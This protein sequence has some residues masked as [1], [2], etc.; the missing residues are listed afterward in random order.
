MDETADFLV[1]GL[2]AM[3]SAALDQLAQSGASVIGLDR[4]APPHTMGSSHGE[5][6]ITRQ[7]V[8]E[9]AAYV[10]FVLDA[11]RI[12][13]ELEA[14]TGESLLRA[15]GA[16]VMAPG[17]GTASHHGKP[18]FVE[19]SIRTARAFAIPHEVLD[20]REVARRFPQFLGLD[21]SETAYFEPGGGYVRPEA[22]IAAQ[23][24][25]ARRRGAAIRTG[26]TVLSIVQN[27]DGVRVET[28]AG[29]FSAGAVL[30]SA[31]AWTA[32]LLGA[33]FDRLLSVKRQLLHWYALDDARAYGP[34]APVYI[35][36]HG[37]TDTEYFYGFPPQAGEA[38]VKVATEQYAAAT[39]AEAADRAVAP[40]ESAAMYRHHI[41]GRLAGATPRAVRSAACLYTVTPDRDFIIDRHPEQERVLVVSACSGHGFKHSAGIGNAVAGL[42]TTGRSPVDLAP[43][44][45]G[46][47]R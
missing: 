4:F 22:C 16:L 13:R 29:S 40:E 47:F 39:T 46:R 31:G 35:W 34:D 14:E 5:T 12:W 28:S 24:S 1:V 18:N 2:G 26:V 3:G 9:G 7:A 11:H 37:T 21:G 42:L 41:A 6:R 8:G 15:C 10:P 44:G 19:N 17:G 33:P 25:R 38:S 43:F 45:L 20:G 23:L 32:P 36:M 27:G 30:V